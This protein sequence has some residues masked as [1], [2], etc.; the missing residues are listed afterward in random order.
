[1]SPF[2]AHRFFFSSYLEPVGADVKSP[3]MS[4]VG[5]GAAGA[6]G[7]GEPGSN[8]EALGSCGKTTTTTSH[9]KYK[10]WAPIR[11]RK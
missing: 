7:A 6:A 9:V 4:A 3:Q 2:S 10:L 8:V 1:L 11:T 5:W